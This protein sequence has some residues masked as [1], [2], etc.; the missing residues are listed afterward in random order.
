MDNTLPTTKIG[1]CGELVGGSLAAMLALTESN[2][3]VRGVNA[4]AIG[5]PVVDWTALFTPDE[6]P[7]SSEV[8]VNTST[9]E[10][11]V[12]PAPTILK[13]LLTMREKLFTKA[14][15]YHDP[16]ASPLLFFRTPSSD[17]PTDLGRLDLEGDLDTAHQTTEAIKKRRSLRKYPPR[18]SNLVLPHMRVDIGIEN[19]LRDQGTDLIE[20]MRRSHSRADAER[21][22]LQ[23]VLPSRIFDVVERPGCGW[24]HKKEIQE[25]GTWFG[26]VLRLSA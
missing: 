20:L 1:V 23:D 5:N 17:L 10:P 2:S 13:S 7:M 19:V 25:I 18:G 12:E 22:V 21:N 9:K 16:F 14:E 3:M 26:E 15:N 4:A 6:A 24:W 11:L 8:P